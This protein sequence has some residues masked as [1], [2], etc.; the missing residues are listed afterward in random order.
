MHDILA[1]LE[2]L[3][4]IH[5]PP[6]IIH[7][8]N[9]CRRYCKQRVR[10]EVDV[11]CVF[12]SPRLLLLCDMELIGK[13]ESRASSSESIP[14][15]ICIASSCSCSRRNEAARSDAIRGDLLARTE[16]ELEEFRRNPDRRSGLGVSLK[17]RN[18]GRALPRRQALDQCGG[19][20]ACWRQGRPELSRTDDARRDAAA[21]ARRDGSADT[22]RR[23][24][25]KRCPSF[26]RACPSS[27][28]YSHGLAAS[29]SALSEFSYFEP[30]Q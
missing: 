27:A 26:V 18:A 20:R 2:Q 5:N 14:S 7:A 10:C 29:R 6:L 17:I 25:H 3:I 4:C 28:R 13:S 16:E 1:L 9:R 21:A 15:R 22:E 8:T 24:C 23:Y 30:A 11:E 19:G 12:S